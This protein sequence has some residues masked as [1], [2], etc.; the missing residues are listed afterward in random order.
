MGIFAVIQKAWVVKFVNFTIKRMM[1][2]S[3][4]KFYMNREENILVT[5]QGE[6]HK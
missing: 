2:K 4:L 5:P 1:I 6:I 3:V